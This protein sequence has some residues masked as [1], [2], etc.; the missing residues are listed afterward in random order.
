MECIVAHDSCEGRLDH[1]L[2]NIDTLFQAPHLTDTPVY[3]ISSESLS[4][5]L[6]AGKNVIDVN[7]A[8]RGRWCSL[9][10]IGHPSLKVTTTGLKYNLSKSSL[11]V[12][13]KSA[14]GT[15]YSGL[16]ICE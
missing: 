4:C 8:C 12:M 10:P 15:V 5:L 3:L 1:V 2:G 9:V 7:E 11:S 16:S 6:R 13:K 14:G